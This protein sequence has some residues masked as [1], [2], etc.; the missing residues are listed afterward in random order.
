MRIDLLRHGECSDQAWLRGRVD[1]ELSDLGWQQMLNQ[2]S[3]LAHYDKIITSSAKRCAEFA[4]KSLQQDASVSIEPAWQERDFGLFDGLSFEELETRFP[5]ALAHYLNN[6]YDHEIPQ[7]ESFHDFK[8]R[9]NQAWLELIQTD[10]ES[11]LL[12]THSGP[13]RLVLQHILGFANQ[14]LFQFELGYAARVS[15]EV[16]PTDSTPFCKLLEIVQAPEPI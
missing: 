5:E 2:R 8:N 11:V 16:I 1:S 3:R 15:I 12:V 6:P 9:I 14:Q 4:M 7:A 13:M 10:V